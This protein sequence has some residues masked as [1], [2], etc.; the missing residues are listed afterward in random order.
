[1]SAVG[2]DFTLLDL[3]ADL[4]ELRRVT[5]WNS[6]GEEFKRYLRAVAPYSLHSNIAA[7]GF[8][9]EQM[10]E[11]GMLAGGQPRP[12]PSEPPW[13]RT[14]YLS[15]VEHRRTHPEVWRIYERAERD[16]SAQRGEGAGIARF[17]LESNG[18][19][20]VVAEEV[21]QALTA[22]AAV[23]PSERQ[24]VEPDEAWSAWI[25]WLRRANLGFEVG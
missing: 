25:A 5:Y 14:M 19:W 7:A 13:D 21:E 10:A 2:Y 6:A 1:M 15:S 4:D 9:R 22:Y 12:F 11:F 17:K 20:I 3:P 24:A 16:A 8:C 18:P 23:S